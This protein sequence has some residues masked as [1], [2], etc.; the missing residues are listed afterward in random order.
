MDTK[1]LEEIGLTNGEIKIYLAL[2]DL[3]SSTAGGIIKKSGL[4]NSV[5]H[6]CVN[7]IIEKGL[8]SYTKKGKVRIYHGA[9][10]ENL[11]IY[12]KDKEKEIEEILPHLKSRQNIR[13]ENQESEVFEGIRGVITLLN[14]LIEDAKQ[15]DEFLFFS[16]DLGEKNEEVQKFYER[17]DWKRRSKSLVVKGIST[18]ALKNLFSKRKYLKMK[19][20]DFPIPANT[21]ICNDKMALIS[22]GEKPTGILIKSKNIVE[23]QKEFFYGIWERL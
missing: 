18:K 17:Y 9:D 20:A 11:I 22:W 14:T 10:P 2:L 13:K 19:Y 21:G 4:Q 8:I 12:L 1:I 15:G 3:G 23:K 5:F 16:A 7:R 6:F